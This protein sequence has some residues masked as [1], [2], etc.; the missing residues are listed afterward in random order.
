MKTNELCSVGGE[1]K[2]GEREQALANDPST[3]FWLREQFEATK[4]RDPVDALKDAQ[5][6]VAVLKARVALTIADIPTSR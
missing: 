4:K 1:V 5:T 6:L 2:V 3:S